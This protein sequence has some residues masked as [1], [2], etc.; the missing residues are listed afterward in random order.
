MKRNFLFPCLIVAVVLLAA[1]VSCNQDLPVGTKALSTPSNLHIQDNVLYWSAV[2]YASGYVVKIDSREEQTST[3]SYSLESLPTGKYRIAVKAVGDGVRYSSSSFSGSIEYINESIDSEGTFGS[4]EELNAKES[5]IG[6][7]INI[8]DASEITSKNIKV[9]YPIFDIEKLMKERLIKSNEHYN[10]FI[11]IDGSTIE[12]YNKKRSMSS[13]STLGMDVYAKASLFGSKLGASA[14]FSLGMAS[15]FTATSKDVES[16][17]FLNVI[18][19]NQNYWL[20]LQSSE[21]RYKELLSEEFKHD[22]YDASFSPARLF[23]KYGTHL[24]TSVAMGGNI[25]MYYTLYSYEKNVDLNSYAALAQKIKTNI[26]AAYGGTKV[27]AGNEG[28]F[29]V[30]YS[31]TEEAKSNGIQVDKRIICVGGGTFGINNEETLYDNYFDWQRSLEEHPVVFGIKDSNSLYP[32]WELLDTSVEGAADRY[33]ELYSYFQKYGDESYDYMCEMYGISPSVDPTE[34]KNIRVDGELVDTGNTIDVKA[35]T[36][37]KIT[38]DVDDFA[39][40]YS[41]T[42]SLCDEGANYIGYEGGKPVTKSYVS[43]DS[44][45]S[46]TMIIDSAIPAGTTYKVK[47][48]AGTISKVL[49]FYVMTSC[50]VVFN[51][52]FSDVFVP[53]Y[54]AVSFGSYIPRPNVS[55]A[56]Y[57]LIGW[58]RDVDN[59]SE[60]DF[61]TDTVNGNLVLY[62]KWEAIKPTVTFNCNGGEGGVQTK[63]IGYNSTVEVPINPT[64]S[65]YR[66]T[67]WFV[68]PEC[69]SKFDFNTKLCDNITLY[70]G[71]D[72]IQY[73]VD[74]VAGEGAYPVASVYTN[75]EK[76]FKITEPNTERPYYTIDGWYRDDKFTNR[77]SFDEYITSNLT[78]Y[79]KWKPTPIRVVFVDDEG[80]TAKTISNEEIPEQVTDI[81]KG[82]RVASV[83][84]PVKEGSDFKGWYFKGNKVPDIGFYTGFTPTDDV[85]KIV[86]VFSDSTYAITINYQ[87]DIGVDG[88]VLPV[89][90]TVTQSYGTEYSIS[91]PIVKGYE[92]PSVTCGTTVCNERITV[93]YRLQSYDLNVKCLDPSGELLGSNVMGSVKYQSSYNFDPVQIKGYTADEPLISGVMDSEG[94]EVSIYYSPIV[95]VASFDV[96]DSNLLTEVS[97]SDASVELTYR[98]TKSLGVPKA[99]YYRFKGWFTKKD[100]GE[101]LTDYNG[102]PLSKTIPDY[103]DEGL[104]CLIDDKTF[105]AHWELEKENYKYVADRKGLESINNNPSD[106]YFIVNDISLAGEQW[107]PIQNFSGVLDGGNHSITGMT[108][109][110]EGRALSE[111]VLYGLFSSI[112]VKGVVK[113][114]KLE[115]CSIKVSANHSGE[116]QIFAGALCGRN[117]GEVNDVGI[118]NASICVLR[119]KSCIG[120]ACGSN[121]GSLTNCTAKGLV[122]GENGD[123][124]GLVG[125]NSGSILDSNVSGVSLRFY[126]ANSNRSLGGFAGILFSGSVLKGCYV[127]GDSYV[128]LGSSSNMHRYNI[129]G[130][131]N[132]CFLKPEVGRLFGR[133]DF[134]TW[135]AN[136]D[137]IS[138]KGNKMLSFGSSADSSDVSMLQDTNRIESDCWFRNGELIGRVD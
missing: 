27:S 5:Y 70:A 33:N 24:L 71:W 59:T 106:N 74:F 111:D 41:K 98:T 8:I 40:K 100:G 128:Y 86:A 29:S 16:Q 134:S 131:H 95:R 53:K 28:G 112:D 61:D 39:T 45:S 19:E 73:R 137:H 133:T 38:F 37:V 108:I 17:Y 114:L 11:S 44:E 120:G 81:S 138:V 105:Y 75:E 25:A 96:N 102:I 115:D 87:F 127:E 64:R 89:S 1:F 103:L 54:M 122:L 68:D 57:R 50:N 32:I 22:L 30:A 79:A 60:F 126:V 65:G 20:M 121:G 123:A 43:F 85:I 46:G 26:E 12:E 125:L 56:G 48:T 80:N 84:N 52:R 10:T 92:T 110:Q 117:Y 116:G 47:I 13:S 4:F 14:S 113:D 23:D 9:T 7:G 62:A 124:G 3:N 118:N 55:K 63:T 69:T 42:F 6:Y 15:R 101:Q 35:G 72:A 31:Y 119:D 97:F 99:D 90:R 18:S 34:I 2:D 91:H 136:K 107:V 94:K 104:W 78:L 109:D 67:G 93:V 129:F 49:T 58:F 130:S 135:Q 51:T 21:S 132:Y 77:F 76:S 66:F 88:A 36:N 83:S 82:F